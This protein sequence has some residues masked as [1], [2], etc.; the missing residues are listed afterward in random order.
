[1]AEAEL[2]E[3]PDIPSNSLVGKSSLNNQEPKKEEL[4]QPANANHEKTT[5]E[6][7]KS[8]FVSSD[9]KSVGEY[10]LWD[11]AVPA[12]RKL[13][14][15]AVCGAAG[16]IFLGE[17]TSTPQGRNLV[18]SR[19]QTLVKKN[20]SS[21]S[22]SKSE[23]RYLTYRGDDFDKYPFDTREHA[24]TVLDTMICELDEYGEVDSGS[25]YEQYCELYDVDIRVPYTAQYRG[26]TNLA[27]AK[28]LPLPG[29]KFYLKLP[30]TVDLSK[31]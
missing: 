24:E 18:R 15:D 30:R 16:R 4:V 26:W 12:I 27:T 19:G 14:Y 7:F 1:M 11:I 25:F 17:G 10:I 6:K 13:F 22:T 3:I 5:G 23:N 8:L 21:I 31:E 20:Y 9:A 2:P 28:V 29:G